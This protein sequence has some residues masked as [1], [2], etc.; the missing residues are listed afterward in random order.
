MYPHRTVL[1]ELHK[2]TLA[3][4]GLSDTLLDACRITDGA[5]GNLGADSGANYSAVLGEMM[6]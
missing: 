3:G 6:S 1:P 5:H 2:V 4:R